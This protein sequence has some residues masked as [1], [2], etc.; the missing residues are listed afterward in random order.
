[1]SA[2]LNSGSLGIPESS[3]ARLIS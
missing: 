2:D 3:A 1:M